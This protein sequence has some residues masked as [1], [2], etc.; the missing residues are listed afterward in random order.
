MKKIR[1][2]SRHPITKLG[3]AWCLIL[4]AETETEGDME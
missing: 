3:D 2:F 4:P 1:P